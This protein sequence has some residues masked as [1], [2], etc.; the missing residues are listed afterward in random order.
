MFRRLRGAV[1]TALVAATAATTIAIAAA[2]TSSDVIT[3]GYTGPLSGGAAAYGTDVQHGLQMAIDEINAAGGVKVG[4]KKAT[5]KLVSLDDQYRPPNSV[6]NAKQLSQQNNAVIV[7]CPHSGGILAIQAMN[8]KQSPKFVLGAYSSEPAILK[9][10]N[11]LTV[12][13]PPAYDSYFKPYIA[14][15]MKRHGKKLGLLA[16]T[17][18]Y[19]KAWA[20]GFRK[21]WEAAGGTVTG[22]YGVDY[23]TTTDFSG[24]VTK[25]LNDKPDVMLVGGPSQPTGLVIKSARNQ[26]YKGGFA[27]MD[28]AKFEQ[29]QDVAPIALLEGTIGVIPFA[30]FGPGVKQFIPRY[31]AKFGGSRPPNSE[32]GLNYETMHV[33]AAAIQEANSTDPAAIMA[34]VPSAA[35]SLPGTYRV[36]DI[37]GVTKAGHLLIRAVAALVSKGKFEPVQVPFTE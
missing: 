34:K 12:M 1:A 27:M 4:G 29:V 22:D 21:A 23:N 33:F 30:D 18:A 10:D 3:I 31:N 14:A 2:Q 5:F 28:Q 35:K 15:E 24:A 26:G 11:H 8:E 20:D 37:N 16:T 13:I 36:A 9:Q 19:G 17:S 6:A 32:V 25:A 7:F